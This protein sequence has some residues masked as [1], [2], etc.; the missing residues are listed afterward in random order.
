MR[1]ELVAV[2]LETTGLDSS[3]D[4]I[5]EIGA[6]R[7][8]DGV[9]TNEFSVLV[10]PG[11]PIPTLVTSLTG[12]RDEDVVG[13]P[14]LLAVLPQL[15]AFVGNSVFVGHNV[16][17][18]A[19]F[20]RRQGILQNNL[21]V[22]TYELASVLLP[23]AP[24][25][26]LTSLTSSFGID[27][28]SAHRAVYDARATAY[29]Y[30]LLWQKALE[31]PYDTLNEITL[32]AQGL[33]WDARPVFEAALRERAPEMGGAVDDLFT[34]D[35]TE[36]KPLRPN[37][38]ITPLNLDE[39]NAIVDD[40]GLLSVKLPNYEHR[41][42]QVEMARA[43]GN[44]FNNTEH[45]M[46]EAGTGTGKSIAYLIPSILWSMQN[47]E[48]VVI[49]TNTI[50]LQEQLIDKDIPTLRDALEIPFTASV[51]KGRGNYLC[52]RRLGAVRRRRPT[53]IDELRTLAK[54][55]VWLLESKTGDRGE[56][57]LRGSEEN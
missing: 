10:D 5:I 40:G 27:I 9:V 24:R 12:L 53:S 54:I 44:A 36:R 20:L 2:D 42:Q 43:I 39:I 33:A 30:W 19:A 4:E 25:Y 6:V 45:L 34:P 26:N 23:R 46:V 8:K 18:D 49:S 15:L 28:G 22:D 38:T 11:R 41:S 16:G 3:T 55:L 31:L 29:L 50:N 7:F 51:M 17:F 52:P 1:G 21:L 32:A 56:I 57:S 13:Q 35:R 48:R 37:D 14:K 47:N